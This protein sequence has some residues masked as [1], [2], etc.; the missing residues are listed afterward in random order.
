M[1]I[2][3]HVDE[4]VPA[5]G[6]GAMATGAALLK[7]RVEARAAS[8][9][10]TAQFLDV[11][12]DEFAWALALLADHLTRAAVEPGKHREPGTLEDAIDRRRRYSKLIG[13]AMRPRAQLAAQSEDGGD[14]RLLQA[15]DEPPGTA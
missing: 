14:D 11:E 2:D 13:N 9:R 10:D 1:V 15:V 12:M 8:L 3:G 5:L 4:V 6:A 7:A